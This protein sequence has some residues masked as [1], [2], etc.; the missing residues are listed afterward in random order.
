MNA[1]ELAIEVIRYLEA[2]E[3]IPFK[4]DDDP[5]ANWNYKTM[6]DELCNYVKLGNF[7]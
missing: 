6:Y 3:Q 1:K 4:I 5:H 2:N 7:A